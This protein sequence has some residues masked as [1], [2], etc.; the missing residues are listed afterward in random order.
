MRKRVF[1][2]QFLDALLQLLAGV[3]NHPRGDFFRADL[4]QKV[5]HYAAP[6]F[7]SFTASAPTFC[8]AT[9]AFANPTANCRIR[10]IT[11]TRSVTEM[12]PRASSRLKRCEHFR[13]SS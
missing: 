3:L 5:R 13:H 2:Q 9:Y 12:A 8:C 6:P 1:C 7:W 4:Q 10:A 11:P